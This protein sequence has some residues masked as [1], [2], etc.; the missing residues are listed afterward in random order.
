M[1]P[2]A[3]LTG[4]LNGSIYNFGLRWVE[5]IPAIT[6]RKWF[7]IFAFLIYATFFT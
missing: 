3:L 5:G 7:L 4:R 2:I 6:K 1:L